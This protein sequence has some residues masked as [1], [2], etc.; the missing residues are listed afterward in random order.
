MSE[1]KTVRGIKVSPWPT[2]PLMLLQSLK[3]V[4]ILIGNDPSQIRFAEQ[5]LGV[6]CT[7]KE[8]VGEEDVLGQ[9]GKLLYRVPSANSV[10]LSPNTK[11]LVGIWSLDPI[12][13]GS[14]GA[15][16]LV[17]YA[18]SLINAKIEKNTLQRYADLLLEEEIQDIRAAIWKAVWLLTGPVPGESTRWPDPWE[19]L[20]GWLPSGLDPGYRLNS[21]YRFLAGFVFAKE[22][23][24]EAARKFG[25]SE[26]RFKVMRNLNLDLDK[27][28][29]SLQEL[30]KWRLHK[31]NPLVSS[32][33][34]SRIWAT[35]SF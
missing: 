18:A 9:E 10:E 8:I 27:V 2:T 25:I 6:L 35:P 19:S 34:I 23:D 33:V 22:D 4:N 20:L 32:L 16:A 24:K 28:E 15:N 14:A 21:L 5:I 11:S 31:S 12:V 30:S 1:N 7:S 29:K 17:K 3:R 13:K 26:S